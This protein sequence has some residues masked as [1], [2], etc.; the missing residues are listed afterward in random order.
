MRTRL[1]IHI[2]TNV[3]WE[4]ATILNSNYSTLR[5]FLTFS[6][7]CFPSDFLSTF[8]HHTL[9]PTGHTKIKAHFWMLQLKMSHFS[10]WDKRLCLFTTYSIQFLQLLYLVFFIP[11]T[12][13]TWGMRCV[14]SIHWL[15]FLIYFSWALSISERE[16]FMSSHLVTSMLVLFVRPLTRC[17]H[18]TSLKACLSFIIVWV[19][20]CKGSVGFI[21]LCKLLS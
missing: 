16:S 11:H 7:F 4:S 21:H 1:H 15:P 18:Y 2:Q 6:F 10:W 9:K 13:H 12:K 19:L 8:I 20:Y 5:I 17:T 3:K 14:Y